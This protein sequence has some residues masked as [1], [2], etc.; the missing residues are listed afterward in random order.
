MGESPS[1]LT[2]M[3]SL[4]FS[5]R[6]PC[7][8]AIAASFRGFS[9]LAA[10]VISAH[11]SLSTLHPPSFL[12]RGS[13]G[14][15][16]CGGAVRHHLFMKETMSNGVSRLEGEFTSF[17]GNTL[18]GLSELGL[19][20]VEQRHVARGARGGFWQ[21]RCELV[22]PARSCSKCGLWS[23]VRTSRWRRVVHSP[24]GKSGVHLLVKCRRY[25]CRDCGLSWEDDLSR[26]V[27]KGR[28][29][30]QKALWWAV[31]SLVLDSM[32][33]RAVSLTLGCSWDCV[34]N[35]V[36]TAAK[37]FLHGDAR[38][39]DAV[40]RIGVDEH[41]W[42][43]TPY[44]S[45][46][47]TV[48]IDLTPRREGKPARLLD[49]VEGRSG[50]AFAKW[51]ARQPDTFRKNVEVVAMDGFNG[52]KQAVRR[53]IPHAKEV[54]DPFHVVRLAGDK[55]TQCRQRL[56]QAAT[57]KRGT[58]HDPLYKA[59]KTLLKTRSLLTSRQHSRL[60]NLFTV[61]AYKP[62][63][64]TWRAYQKII[65]CYNTANKQQ[66]LHMMQ[67][68]VNNINESPRNAPPELKTLG[69]TLK[70]RLPDILAYFTHDHSSNGPTEAINGRLEHLR[71]IALG[72]RNPTNYTMRSLLHT[73]GL[74]QTIQHHIN[75][76]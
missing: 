30:S 72:F 4:S 22:E 48:I 43:H 63:H 65:T 18:L 15:C 74:T 23:P 17:D 58:K 10:S 44:G 49:M 36:L 55:V 13:S 37:D 20:G 29:L 60:A 53:V 14:F 54:L 76:P 68:L 51:L 61:D 62:L 21:V 8:I 39:L 38:R 66:A 42:R 75:H 27:Q 57:G 1:W 56:Q 32:S 12:L 45:K 24:L 26:I 5:S 41:V 40:N 28:C 52:Y 3:S 25:Q 35:A 19:R 7:P 67:E 2:L 31:S 69:R 46:Y 34:N 50:T 59:R 47:V 16:V 9:C 33:V 73:G 71:G 64:D 6:V 70:R 11:Q